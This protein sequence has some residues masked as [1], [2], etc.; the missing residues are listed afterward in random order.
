[1]RYDGIPNALGHAC[2][3][4]LILYLDTWVA[5]HLIFAYLKT[6]G[7]AHS[8]YRAALGLHPVKKKKSTKSGLAA[9]G[10]DRLD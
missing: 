1:M 2:L 3:N 5:N 10:V 9:Y 7:Q 4:H 6:S 8:I